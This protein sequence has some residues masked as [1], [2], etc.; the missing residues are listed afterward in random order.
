MNTATPDPTTHT[1]Y[2]GDCR[3]ALAG[4]P[5]ASVDAIVTDPPYELTS[6]T[7][8]G[9]FMGKTW[10]A[11]GAA[12]DPATWREAYRVLRPGG[13]ILAFGG[14]RTVHRLAVAIEDAGFEIR[15]TL[16][17]TYGTGFAKGMDVNKMFTKAAMKADADQ[18]DELLA[19][20]QTWVGWNTSL[21]PSHEPIVL[22]RKPINMTLLQNLLTHAVGAI[23]IGQ[24]RIPYANLADETESKNKNRHG[25]FGTPHGGNAVYGDYSM[26]GTRENYDPDARFPTNTLFT[27]HQNCHPHGP[28]TQTCDNACPIRRLDELTAETFPPVGGVGVSRFFFN[29]Q[30]NPAD[31]E[32]GHTL[33]FRKANTAERPIVNGVAHV[34]V[35]PLALIRYL[36][37][38][39][40][41][42][43]G[44]VIDLFAGSG[45]TMEAAYLEH[46]NS[47]TVE[48][49]HEHV[50]LIQA[51]A[52]RNTITLTIPTRDPVT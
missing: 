31:D 47:I 14:A 39:I 34:A 28:T 49:D 20:A 43:G 9:G 35:K 27:H 50:P 2:I 4:I 37:R 11:T 22:A 6:K 52:D 44:T 24:T 19:A 1:L 18:R 23:N 33:Y 15:D 46:V 8:K 5:D 21:K 42:P 45:T 38:L 30:W 17:W 25:D 41:P 7:G 10:D 29:S 51:R 13:H 32:F 3:T 48:E 40:T 12:F 26:M 16:H 36:V